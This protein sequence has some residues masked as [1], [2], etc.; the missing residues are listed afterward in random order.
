ML[1][2]LA[3]LTLATAVPQADIEP[4][5]GEQV[6]RDMRARYAESWYETFTFVQDARFY[7][8]D[9]EIARVETWYETMRIPGE[10]RID[11]WPIS[12]GNGVIFNDD[13][14]YSITGGQPQ[15]AQPMVHSLLVMGFDVY[16]QPPDTT[17]AKVR[18]LGVDLSRSYE[19]TW[20]GRDVVVV[21]SSSPNDMASYQFWIDR[22]RLVMLREL[23]GPTE[24]RF[25]AYEP[26]DEAW[27]ATRVEF[28]RDGEMTLE[29]I[30]R[31]MRFNV[32]IEDGVF[33]PRE[34]RVPE[35]VREASGSRE[36]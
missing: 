11:I 17:I 18:S 2:A 13:V 3:A 30:Y 19:T 27:V 35:W 16:R 28:Y 10:L 1:T 31:D 8:D 6:I 34:N 23:N 22:E 9:G 32:A 5:T 12:S 33:D 7:G 4:D 25:T 29:E 26:A 36:E 24:V 14:A 21:G 20:D 15:T